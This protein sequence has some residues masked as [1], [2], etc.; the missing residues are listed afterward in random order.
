MMPGPKVS[1]GMM[2]CVQN[3][4]KK[5][6]DRLW[7]FAKTYMWMEDGENAG[8]FA[9][10]VQPDGTKNSHGPAPDGE[11]YFA[12][13]L[14]LLQTAGETERAF[15]IIPKRQGLSSMNVFIKVKMESPAILCGSLPIS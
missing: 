6:F 10:S 2:M 3:N 13:A 11:E 4:W 8:Y 1:Y 7:K 15:I 12:M 14:F 5:E 9:W